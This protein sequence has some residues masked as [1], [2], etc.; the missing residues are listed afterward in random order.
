M[1]TRSVFIWN[2]LSQ[3]GTTGIQFLSTIVLAR[4]LSPDDYGIVGMCNIFIAFSCMMVDS[5]MGG[6]LL[7][8]KEVSKT[9]YSTL[10]YYNL[11]VS[12]VI[13]I[14]LFFFAPL[15]AE[16]YER[17]ELVSI[18]R[19]LGLSI[20]FQAFR[21]VQRVIIFR[22]LEFKYIAIVNIVSGVLSFI[23]AVYLAYMG[24]GYWAL[25]LQ[26]V[27]GSLLSTGMMMFHNRFIPLMTFSVS[28]FRYQFDFGIK[29]LGADTLRTIASNISSNLIAKVMPLKVTGYYVQSSR[30]TN[31]AVTFLGSIMDQAVF[32]LMAK[33][34]EKTQ[35]RQFFQ[36]I[37]TCLFEVLCIG[38]LLLVILSDQIISIMLGAQW[39]EASWIFS[40]LAL[41]IL[42]NT[43][44]M[45][46]RNVLKSLGDTGSVLKMQVIKSI[47]VILGLLMGLPF[48]V[49]GIVW[50]YVISEIIVTIYVIRFLRDQLSIT[51]KDC[52]HYSYKSFI[53]SL[54]SVVTIFL[55]L[56]IPSFSRCTSIICA[57]I[58]I[59]IYIVV[60][61][62][63]GD[64]IT[65]KVLNR[66]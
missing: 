22:N 8:K 32:P 54:G 11:G 35:I 14:G 25:I 46:I 27:L 40:V 41:G 49:S 9:D 5:E 1:R 57:F 36:A 51:L 37:Y 48:G 39:I 45:L 4:L 29:L 33:M 59:F 6:A 34:E 24:Y 17:F 65:M 30:M 7:K 19:V 38:T 3:L 43:I 26:Q 60:L 44:Q 55:F 58:S 20:L 12:I 61:L 13:Y 15:I 2:I 62:L 21:V 47:F 18:I 23:C 66:K 64:S 53:A 28:S 42:P 63:Q 31:Y 50:G 56:L 52:F 10:F 16:Y